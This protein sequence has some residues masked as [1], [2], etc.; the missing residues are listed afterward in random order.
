MSSALAVPWA[1]WRRSWRP[2]ASPRV[3]RRLHRPVGESGQHVL[4]RHAVDVQQR[5]QRGRPDGVHLRPGDSS[6]GTVDIANT[7][8]L[9]GA[10]TLVKSSLTDSD[11]ANPLS[12]KLNVVVDDCGAFSGATAPSC[13]DGDEVTKYSGALADMSTSGHAVA[14]LGTF[15]SNDKHRYR[16]RVTLDTTA[17][18][19]YQ[20]DSSTAAFTWNAA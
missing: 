20:G 14:A 1:R 13:T 12:A 4:H 5:R 8:S 16:F 2:P 19:A 3:R 17:G 9:S 15:A 11:T 6:T 7:G 18:N 10:F